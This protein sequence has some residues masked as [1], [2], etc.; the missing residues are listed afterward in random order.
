MKTKARKRPMLVW[1]RVGA[2][3][4]SRLLYCSKKRCKPARC[5]QPRLKTQKRG[6]HTLRIAVKCGRY[7]LFHEPIKI[8]LGRKGKRVY[9]R[10]FTKTG[11]K[12]IS[13]PSGT[14]IVRVRFGGDAAFKFKAKTR[15]VK[16]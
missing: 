8:L 5:K 7:R 6:G 16:L 9:K 2:L 15:K 11:Y 3:A 4:S 14:S 13:I 10:F 12:T 1:G